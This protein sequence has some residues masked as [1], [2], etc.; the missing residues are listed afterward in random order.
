MKSLQEE[1]NL[2]VEIA[3]IKFKNPIV[4]A[5][6]TFGF[7]KEYS[8]FV[9]LSKLGGIVFKS[10][11]LQPCPGNPPPRIFETS[12]GLLNSIG[13]ENPGVENFMKFYLPGLKEISTN[14]IASIAGG[15]VEEYAAVAGRLGESEVISALEL[16]ISCPNVR[17]GGMQFGVSPSASAEV[18]KSVKSVTDKPVIVKLSPNV[19][20]IVE[21]ARS[22]AAAGADALSMINTLTGMAI[23]IYRR[24][25]VL[26][27]IKGGLSGP[28]VK[29]VA[30]RAVWDVYREVGL[31]II[32]MGGITCARDALEFIMAGAR[33]VAAGTVN[34]IN[35]EATIDILEGITFFL[36]ENGIPDINSL[37]GAA[38]NQIQGF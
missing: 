12:S 1:P 2:A 17:H 25:P 19:T 21:I 37:V 9:D 20:N 6:G 32:G 29:P 26:G 4:T 5:S 30:V 7:G 3:G 28:A 35:P 22:V 31:P 14:I 36:K 38:H 18:V 15:A 23:D 27:N 11:T 8:V 33:A 10:L 24:R 16:N 34:F 13:L